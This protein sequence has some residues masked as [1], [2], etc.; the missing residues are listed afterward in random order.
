[1]IGCLFFY[2]MHQ[3]NFFFDKIKVLTVAENHNYLL[4]E[5]KILE[6][7]TYIYVVQIIT[8]QTYRS[9]KYFFTLLIILNISFA[10]SS[11]QLGQYT[12]YMLNN[13]RSNVAYAGLDNSLSAT[14][15]FRGQWVGLEGSPTMQNVNVHMPMYYIK[16]AVGL[17]IENITLGAEQNLSATISYAYHK[18]VGDNGILSFGAGGG[19]YQKSL[20]GSI[21]RTPGGNYD[22]NIPVINHNDLLLTE[23]KQ[24]AIT[25]I[26]NAGV[27]FQTEKI[28]I[29]AS[30]NNII[31]PKI[32]LNDNINFQLK[33]HYLLTLAYNWNMSN[34]LSI[35]PTIIAKSDLIETQIEI[36]TIVTYNDNIF[37]GATFRGY[38]KNTI[39]AAAFIAGIKLSEK[40]T[41]AY[42]YDLTLSPYNSVSNGSH[43]ILINYNLN[44]KIGAGVPPRII[45]NPRFLE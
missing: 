24:G 10:A 26:F 32:N 31:E 29:G 14:G 37:G 22:E 19:I 21:L 33:R 9:M 45:H 28:E 43:E 44:K 8:L 13:Y 23:G 20:D 18:P 17:N 38:S 41:L 7:D 2:K 42:S 36:S 5:N 12:M 6:K 15:V 39:D 27:Y 35:Q 1:M 30:A 25:P 11:Q 34:L 40:I 16:G 3:I 4:Q